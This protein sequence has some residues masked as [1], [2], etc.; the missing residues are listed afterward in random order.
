MSA[1][2]LPSTRFSS[3]WVGLRNV[4][5]IGLEAA[6]VAFDLRKSVVVDDTLQT[7]NPHIFAS[8]LPGTAAHGA[9]T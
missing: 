6:G 1:V 3:V 8:S 9:A 4:E 2:R 5:G 7:S